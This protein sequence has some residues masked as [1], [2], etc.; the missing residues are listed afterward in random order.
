VEGVKFLRRIRRV[1]GDQ[2]RG[3]ECGSGVGGVIVRW[4]HRRRRRKAVVI[5][6]EMRVGVTIGHKTIADKIG[7]GEARGGLNGGDVSDGA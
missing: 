6:N 4:I 1:L 5:Q 2:V 7:S 3:G